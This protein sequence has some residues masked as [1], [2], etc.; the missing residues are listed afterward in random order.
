MSRGLRVALC[1]L[2]ATTAGC[3][4][5]AYSKDADD[6]NAGRLT[7]SGSSTCAP[8]IAVIA[9]RFEQQHPGV[10]V[11][12]QS[13]GSSRGIADVESGLADIGMSSRDLTPDEAATRVGTA[14][15]V[16][17][18]CFLV[19]DTNHVPP[20]STD[21]LRGIFSGLIMNWRD[22]GGPDARVTVISRAVGR[23]EL[24]LVTAFLGLPEQEIDADAIAGENQQGIKQVATNPEAITFMSTGAALAERDLGTPVRLLP[25]DGV[26]P[27]VESIA[28]ARYALVRPLILVTPRDASALATRFIEFATSTAVADIVHDHSYVPAAP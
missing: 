6:D 5:A 22:V 11:D 23:S 10:R 17:G 13:G 3:A 8:A 28:T 20:L 27:T 15:A 4:E 2:L 25:L 24:S 21:Q 16:D 26:D 12:V 18:V 9:R 7:V 19:H 14:F 1:L